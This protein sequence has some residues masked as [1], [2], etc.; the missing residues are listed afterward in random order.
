MNHDDAVS[1]AMFWTGLMMVLAPVVFFGTVVF[2]WW[3]KKRK[4]GLGAGG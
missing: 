2:V 3:W 4:R 1:L